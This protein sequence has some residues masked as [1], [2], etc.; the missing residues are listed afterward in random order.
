VSPWIE[1]PDDSEAEAHFRSLP[2]A[3]LGD[4]RLNVEMTS[5][6]GRKWKRQIAHA[7]AALGG[8]SAINRRNCAASAAI[9]RFQFGRFHMA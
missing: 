5:S 4:F 9:D 1:H 8:C 7:F 3:L 2:F 6:A